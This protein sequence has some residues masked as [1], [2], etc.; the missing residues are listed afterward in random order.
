MKESG[1]RPPPMKAARRVSLPPGPPTS[2]RHRNIDHCSCFEGAPTPTAAARL[3]LVY[4]ARRPHEDAVAAP[5]ETNTRRGDE[6]ED[7]QAR[8]PARG[9]RGRLAVERVHLVAVQVVLGGVPRRRRADAYSSGSGGLCPCHW[10]S[11]SNRC[12]PLH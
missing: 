10:R 3:L 6:R 1:P 5:L 2:A 9:F 8:V 12:A 11:W 7:D 4:G